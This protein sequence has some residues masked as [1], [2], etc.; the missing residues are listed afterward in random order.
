M[1]A[2]LEV[3]P[4]EKPFDIQ[5]SKPQIHPAENP[6][7]E[8]IDNESDSELNPFGD[9]I[10]EEAEAKTTKT[11]QFSNPF[12]ESADEPTG[13]PFGGNESDSPEAGNP[14]GDDDSPDAGNPFGDDTDDA[15]SDANNPFH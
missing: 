1:K 5:L 8:S 3:S 2:I 12:G 14:F 13:N 10:E 6:F 7:G 15:E 9:A 4:E 11:F